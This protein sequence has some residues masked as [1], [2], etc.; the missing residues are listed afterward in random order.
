MEKGTLG[1]ESLRYAVRRFP[2][3]HFISP[4]DHQKTK[5]EFIIRIE[6]H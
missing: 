5:L 6:E 1:E 2:V 4:A 3:S